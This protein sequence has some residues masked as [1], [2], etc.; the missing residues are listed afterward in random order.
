MKQKTNKKKQYYAEAIMDIMSWKKNIHDTLL[1][2]F[3]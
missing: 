1:Y 2:L 3:N